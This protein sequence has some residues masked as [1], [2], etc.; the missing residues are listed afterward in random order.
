MLPWENSAI[1][2]ME[3]YGTDAVL[4]SACK[5]AK[6]ALLYVIDTRL[7]IQNDTK[8]YAANSERLL[9]V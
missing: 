6:L 3:K 9:K 2:M 1:R 7:I 4:C 5:K 8:I